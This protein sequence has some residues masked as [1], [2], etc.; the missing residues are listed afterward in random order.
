MRDTLSTNRERTRLR[1][2]DSV[3]SFPAILKSMRSVDGDKNGANLK[4]WSVLL[5]CT[6]LSFLVFFF[7][8]RRLLFLCFNTR[9]PCDRFKIDRAPWDHTKEEE[10]IFF[11]SSSSPFPF[12]L[13]VFFLAFFSIFQF[14]FACDYFLSL[15]LSL[16]LTLSL[17]HTHSL[18][19]SL[20]FSLFKDVHHS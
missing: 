13:L 14:A 10:K 19:L 12:F 16:S 5:V 8:V 17:S 6:I 1:V 3:K 11:S 20:S 2:A 18:S 4:K 9:P 15:S 7:L